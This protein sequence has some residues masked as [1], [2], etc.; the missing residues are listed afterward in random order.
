MRLAAALATLALCATTLAE[1]PFSLE[2][3]PGQLP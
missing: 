2:L 3:T 1:E